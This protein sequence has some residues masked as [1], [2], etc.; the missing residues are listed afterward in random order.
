MD[1]YEFMQDSDD[2]TIIEYSRIKSETDKAWLL[3]LDDGEREW[4]PKSVCVLDKENFEIEVPMWL[5]EQ[6]GLT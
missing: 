1:D 6:K 4:F 2:F 5:A 3:I